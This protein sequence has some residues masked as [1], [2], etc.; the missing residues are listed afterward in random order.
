MR[1]NVSRLQDAAHHDDALCSG[2]EDFKEI[3]ELDPADAENGDF[4]QLMHAGD[5]CEADSGASSFCRRGKK[6]AEADVIRTRLR[7]GHGLLD[8]VR[9]FPNQR[10]RHF[11]RQRT[12]RSPASIAH[13]EVLLPHMRTICTDTRDEFGV[14]VDDKRNA[15][16][17]QDRLDA[18]GEFFDKMLIIPFCPELHDTGTTYAHLLGNTLN[19]SHRCIA[20]ID[21]AVEPCGG[22]GGGCR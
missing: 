3:G 12:A 18:I 19:I 10:Q 20:E 8:G 1:R 22:K 16:S 13:R 7:S 5:L 6:W 9:A 17:R 4:N 14:V 11:A 21:D 15:R 2:S